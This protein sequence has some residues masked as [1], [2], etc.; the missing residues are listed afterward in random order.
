MG[1]KASLYMLCVNMELELRMMESMED[2]TAATMEDKAE[3][4]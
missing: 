2:I 1:L 4:K 3:A